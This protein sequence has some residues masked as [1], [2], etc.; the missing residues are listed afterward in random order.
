MLDT[1]RVEARLSSARAH[2]DEIGQRAE[3]E[4]LLAFLGNFSDPKA[5][6]CVLFHDHAPHSFSFQ[7]HVKGE[8]GAWRHWFSGGLIYHGPHDGHGSGAAPTLSVS[9][10]PAHGWQVHT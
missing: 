6:R 7:M 3:F 10:I 4:K 8:D 9:L 2:A 5:T 1:S